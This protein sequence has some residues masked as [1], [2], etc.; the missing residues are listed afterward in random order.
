MPPGGRF[1]AF[2]DELRRSWRAAVGLDVVATVDSTNDRARR[3]LESRATRSPE[4]PH[5]FVAWTQ[6][7]GRGRRGSSW[8]SPAGAGV[9]ASVLVPIADPERLAGLPLLL[10]VVVGEAVR[11]LGV[12]GCGIKWPND[13][14]VN[15]AKLGGLLVESVS[16]GEKPRAALLGLGVNYRRPEERQLASRAVGLQELLA[17][18]PNLAT[19][20]RVLLEALLGELS[21]YR[22][23]ATADLVSRFEALSVHRIGDRLSCRTP[24]ETVVGDFAGIDPRG[25]LRLVVADGERRIS[26]GEIVES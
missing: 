23:S 12:S 15:G 22:P 14:L 17:S 18:P 25:F 11:G 5:V 4:E 6:T 2:E 10:P 7:A 19:V 24:A 16:S 9:Y 3:A 20:T 13:L 8:S 26:S 21:A 1:E